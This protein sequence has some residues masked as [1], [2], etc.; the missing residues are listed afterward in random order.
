MNRE[1][2]DSLLGNQEVI[3]F[4]N[5]SS[6]HFKSEDKKLI[7]GFFFIHEGLPNYSLPPKTRIIL[8]VSR[9]E[10]ILPEL[11]VVQGKNNLLILANSH[12]PSYAC[13]YRITIDE[14]T[15]SASVVIEDMPLLGEGLVTDD[16]KNGLS[17][18]L[19]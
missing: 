19:I 10:E 3:K 7:V 5:H 12:D 2:Y 14:I 17:V 15:K 13:T 16:E 6:K 9:A 11:S 8:K 1:K 18:P 4:T